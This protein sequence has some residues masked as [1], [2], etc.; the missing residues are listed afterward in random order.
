MLL[1]GALVVLG[2]SLVA[3]QGA[4]QGPAANGAAPR[5][6]DRRPDLQGVWNYAAGTPLERPA[7]YAGREFLTDEELARAERELRERANADDGMAQEPPR[8]SIG[9]TTS[10]GLR[11]GRRSLHGEPHS[12]SI[13]RMAGCRRLPATPN[14]VESPAPNI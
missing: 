6:P 12:S 2:L 11:G 9:K 13:R 1:R 10:S 14:V 4:L 3:G 8:M 7:A 5:A